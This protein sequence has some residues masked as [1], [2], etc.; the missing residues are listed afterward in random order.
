MG[1]RFYVRLAPIL[2]A[3]FFLTGC[4]DELAAIY[5]E[6]APHVINHPAYLFE[7]DGRGRFASFSPATGA[8]V[9]GDARAAIAFDV[10]RDGDQDLLVTH[11][12]ASPVLLLN[13]T[14]G[15]GHWLDL[16]LV[17]AGGVNRNAIGARVVVRLGT[18]GFHY[19]VVGGGSYLS[20]RPYEIHVG[21][22]TA[23]QV[24]QVEVTWPDGH[25][26]VVANPGVDQRIVIQY[27]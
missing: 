8:E 25:T 19:E 13:Q 17:G 1:R 21:L 15:A 2:L 18:D 23:T 14:T 4:I 22:G 24:T 12:N 3:M 11:M 20:G 7:N 16:K 6:F 9:R 5:L 27:Q 10:D 26:N